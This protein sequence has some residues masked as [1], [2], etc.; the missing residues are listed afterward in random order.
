MMLFTGCLSSGKPEE[1]SGDSESETCTESETLTETASE[2]EESPD[3]HVK[4]TTP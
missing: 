4:I 1:T 2:T 3:G